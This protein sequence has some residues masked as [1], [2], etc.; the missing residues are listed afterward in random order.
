MNKNIK[1]SEFKKNAIITILVIIALGLL[2]L[3]IFNNKETL[4]DIKDLSYKSDTFSYVVRNA[5]YSTGIVELKGYAEVVDRKMPNNSNDSYVLFHILESSSKSFDNFLKTMVKNDS[6][7]YYVRENAI[8]IGCSLEDGT[9]SM[10]SV[11]DR[12]KQN[13]NEWSI[14]KLSPSDSKTVLSSSKD[15]PISIVIKKELGWQ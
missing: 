13:E 5:G 8:G 10:E 6:N 7:G 4:L 12:Y 1:K 2:Y 15:K 14:M 11:A 3:I 9:I